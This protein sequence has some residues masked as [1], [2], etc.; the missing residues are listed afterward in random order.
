MVS[1]KYTN[2]M[3]AHLPRKIRKNLS[4]SFI[5]GNTKNR[6]WQC[7][8][9]STKYRGF[10]LTTRCIHQIR[11]LQNSSI[12]VKTVKLLFNILLYINLTRIIREGLNP[13][14][15]KRSFGLSNSGE[16]A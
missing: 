10:I 12:T 9:H 2:A 3:N 15:G 8:E 7:F 5:K 14:W 1:N 11:L 6:V 13:L 4:S 16:V